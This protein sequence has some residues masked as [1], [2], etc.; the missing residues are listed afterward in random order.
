MINFVQKNDFS[1]FE[2]KYLVKKYILKKRENI[3]Y[4]IDSRF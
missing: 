1:N 4:I 2:N 3:I